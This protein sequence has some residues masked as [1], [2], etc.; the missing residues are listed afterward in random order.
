MVLVIGADHLGSIR[1]NLAALGLGPVVH[2]TGR[3]ERRVDIPADTKLVLV[4]IDYVNHN[5]A[6]WV[7]EQAKSREIPVVFS[8]RSWSAVCQSLANCSGCSV[9]AICTN[10]DLKT[11]AVG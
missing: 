3:N 8:R 10:L 11:E 4:L 5:L 9:A 1:G 6:R 7:K 2:V